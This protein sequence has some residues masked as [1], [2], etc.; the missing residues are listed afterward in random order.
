MPISGIIERRRD[1]RGSTRRRK[2]S[3]SGAG[4]AQDLGDRF[5]RG[6]AVAA[7]RARALRSVE[8]RGIETRLAGEARS[9]HP[10]ALGQAVDGGPDAVVRQHGGQTFAELRR[11]ASVGNSNLARKLKFVRDGSSQYRTQASSF[12]AHPAVVPSCLSPTPRTRVP[13]DALDLQNLSAKASGGGR[14]A[15]RFD[16]APVDRRM[17]II[18]FSTA[19][20]VARDR[21]QALRRAR[22][23]RC[24]SRS[25]PRRSARLCV[26][27]RRAAA[28]CSRISTRPL[29]LSAVR[30]AKP[31]PLGPDGRHVFPDLAAMIGRC[32]PLARPLLHALDAET[33]TSSRSR[34]AR[35]AAARP[36][37]EDDPRLGGRGFG[38]R[39]PNPV[40]LAAGFDKQCEVPDALLGARLRLRR[41]RRRRAAAPARQPAPARLPPAR[42]RG[43]HQP[44]RPQQRRARRRR[45]R[46]SRRGTARPASSASTS[47]PTRTARDRVADYV[48]CIR[49][50]APRSSTSSPSTSRR[51]TRRA[52]ATSR[53]RLS[54]RSSRPRRRG[55]RRAARQGER[56]ARSS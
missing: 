23:P 9:G 55:P 14:G 36:P 28:T 29:P 25:R 7:F 39:F 4:G 40:G 18:H 2:S 26:T 53:A 48:A 21:R 24:W 1:P 6:P 38:R 51:P 37:A 17:A 52:C 42:G 11:S 15:G 44:L 34:P 10:V 46:G 35:D 41:D 16:G 56:S 5:G 45:A 30:W 19:A 20:Q 12:R 8:A 43:G 3:R 13:D 22:R 50:L 33:P 32:F 47:A 31:L 49:G 27:S 54:R